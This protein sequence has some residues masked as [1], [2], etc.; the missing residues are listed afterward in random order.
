MTPLLPK[1]SPHRFHPSHD[2]GIPV[3]QFN[4]AEILTDNALRRVLLAARYAHNGRT[5]RIL[6]VAVVAAR[7]EPTRSIPSLV[8]PLSFLLSCLSSSSLFCRPSSKFFSDVAVPCERGGEER[9]RRQSVQ[10]RIER[11][12][13][14]RGGDTLR[15][16]SY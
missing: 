10:V 3:V 7:R 5:A 2:L 12:S 11:R 8:Y 16:Q 9:R 6:V 14:W 13:R 1:I 4:N 15:D